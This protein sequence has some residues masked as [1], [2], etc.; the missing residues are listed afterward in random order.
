M[1]K[2][3]TN[4]FPDNERALGTTVGSL[5]IPL[6]CITGLVIGPFFVSEANFVSGKEDMTYYMLISACI[7]TVLSFCPLFFYREKPPTYPSK[8]AMSSESEQFDFKK[9]LKALLANKNYIFMVISFNM[10][11]GIYT[12][13]G[14]IINNLVHPFG[15]TG[16]DSSIFGAVFIFSGLVGSFVAS[17][18]LDKTQ[19]YLHSLRFVVFG[20]IFFTFFI[21]FTLPSQKVWLLA[22]NISLLGFFILPMIPIG[23]SFSVE[24]TY[25]VSE[26]MSNGLMV[27]FSQII[28]TV[29]TFVATKVAGYKPERQYCTFLFLGMMVVAAVATLFIK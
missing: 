23:Y 13:L 11:Y 6:G 20:A 2:Q 24:L 12:C 10:L 25:P 5:S 8:S 22:I 26:A 14:A 7:I 29:I 3:A 28:G 19:L 4:W 16:S 15:Y 18:I 17:S 21:L 1:S 27:F 9:D